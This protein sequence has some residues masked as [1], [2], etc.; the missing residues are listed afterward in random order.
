MATAPASSSSDYGFGSAFADDDAFDFAAANGGAAAASSPYANPFATDATGRS[1]S[2]G[3]GARPSDTA[4]LYPMD[5]FTNPA[6]G[7]PN[8]PGYYASSSSSSAAGGPRIDLA[9]VGRI[10]PGTVAPVLGVYPRGGGA[11]RAGTGPSGLD[12]VFPEDYKPT[13]KKS[14]QEQLTYLAGSAYLFGAL[15]GGALGLAVAMRESAGKTGKL[16]LNAVLNTASKR[17]A[18]YANSLGVLALLFSVSETGFHNMTHDDTA[19][20]Y[21]GAGALT[22]AIFKSTRGIRMAGIWGVG[23]AAVALGAVYASR[24][25]FYGRGLQGVL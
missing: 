14:G 19:L 12:Y 6:A 25:G 17:G 8:T 18:L 7:Y 20:N 9:G 5:N 22:G 24:Q 23:G 3:A 11:M 1:T 4:D 2:A 16:R 15:S 21:A 10:N 13:R